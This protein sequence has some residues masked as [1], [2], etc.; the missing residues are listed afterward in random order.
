MKP[1]NVTLRRRLA[2]VDSQLEAE[3]LPSRHSPRLKEERQRRLTEEKITIQSSLDSIV[4][5]ILTLPVEITAEI[6]FHC[7]PRHPSFPSAR[8]APMLLGRI[9]RQWRNIACSTP[10]LWAHL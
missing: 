1:K 10:R 5:P 4:Y 6:F 8:I 7:L 3:S 2:S 9:C